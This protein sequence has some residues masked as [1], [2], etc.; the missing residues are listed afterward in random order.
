MGRRFSKNVAA[1][2]PAS[3]GV[4]RRPWASPGVPGRPQASLGV[5]GRRARRAVAAL[6]V[7]SGSPRAAS[8]PRC[9]GAQS[10]GGRALGGD[11]A[12]PGH[13]PLHER[14][15]PARRPRGCPSRERPGPGTRSPGAG[16]HDAAQCCM[17]KRC[18]W[19]RRADGRPAAGSARARAQDVARLK[20]VPGAQRQAR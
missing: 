20:R 4:P 11:L 8:R 6:L 16:Q 17:C 18:A 14:G 9:Y 2:S 19:R 7:R 13:R 1:A 12:C 15:A 3:P 10:D 5:P